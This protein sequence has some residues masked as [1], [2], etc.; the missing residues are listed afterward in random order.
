MNAAK[1]IPT[2]VICG[3]LLTAC[4]SYPKGSPPSSAKN[5]PI[6]PGAE[7]VQTAI[8]KESRLEPTRVMTFRTEDDRN[9][10]VEYY[11]DLLTR[12]GWEHEM[13][14]FQDYVSFY[15]VEGCPVYGLELSVTPQETTGSA[16]K[17]E[18]NAT[19]CH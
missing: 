9:T 14:Q 17:L 16:V 1:C 19:P 12:D 8:V 11:I 6:Y 13:A 18:L 15:W 7:A 5:L 4:S 10:V 3:M 2:F